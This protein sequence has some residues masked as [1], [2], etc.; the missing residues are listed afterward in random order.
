[1]LTGKKASAPPVD[2][3]NSPLTPGYF[4][5]GL[6]F[7]VPLPRLLERFLCFTATS[8][9]YKGD[10][11]PKRSITGKSALQIQ[12]KKQVAYLKFWTAVYGA[13]TGTANNRISSEMGQ[14]VKESRRD[15]DSYKKKKTWYK[16]TADNQ[17]LHKY[18]TRDA[19]LLILHRERWVTKR[20]AAQNF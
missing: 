12:G 2:G 11:F 20:D 9:S 15:T 14:P 1:M 5:L 19:L 4:F 18:W 8:T 13:Q 17:D 6:G 10:H 7:P 16:S 3:G